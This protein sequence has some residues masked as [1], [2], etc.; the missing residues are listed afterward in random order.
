MDAVAEDEKD[1]KTTPRITDT[2]CHRQTRLNLLMIP[3]PY[4]A[5]YSFEMHGLG[6]ENPHTAPPRVMNLGINKT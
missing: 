2:H 6:E 1:D 5:W 4:D 3:S